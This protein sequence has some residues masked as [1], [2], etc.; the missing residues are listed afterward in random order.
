MSK[1]D[2]LW[3][4]GA[5]AM[6]TFAVLGLI[7]I[8]RIGA[9]LRKEIAPDDFRFGESDR[10]SGHVSLP[11]R[12]MMILLEM[13]VLFYVICIMAYMTDTV[14]KVLLLAAWLYVGLRAVH[15]AIHLTS[16]KVLHRLIAF[17]ASNVVLIAMWVIFFLRL[18]TQ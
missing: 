5:L 10:V 17:T 3:P 11:N 18:A 13:P 2:I 9:A 14:G 12:A 4:M 8:R 1:L 7:P 6:L 15:T 16:N